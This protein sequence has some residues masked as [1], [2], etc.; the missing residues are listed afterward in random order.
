MIHEAVICTLDP[1]GGP[2]C[3]PLGYRLAQAA[4]AAAGATGATTD[5]QAAGE[6]E[7]L[8]APFVPSRTLDNLRRT[9]QAVLSLTDDVRVIAGALTGRRAWPLVPAQ[10]VH[11]FRLAAALAHRELAVVEIGGDPVRP[12]CRCR[13]V[14]AA[15][16]APFLGFNRAQ[17]AVVEAAILVSRLDRLPRARVASELEYL[18]GAVDKTAGP[19]EREAWG[20]LMA[21][22]AA[23]GGAAPG[24]LMD[25]ASTEGAA[26]GGPA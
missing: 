5:A 15:T 1:D 13:T 25:G 23:Q 8:L 18:Q 21:H 19:R 26:P 3:A 10:A 12:E 16:H 17:A 24:A 6:E 4:T 20:W 14:H 22:W 9:G 2:R 7:V 11:G